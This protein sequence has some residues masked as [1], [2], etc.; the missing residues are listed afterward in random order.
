MET[1]NNPPS[2]P[3]V[4]RYGGYE[5]EGG[6][7]ATAMI[8]LYRA[9]ITR[10][11]SWRSRLDV[12]TNWAVVAMGAALSFAFGQPNTHHSVILLFN[13]LITLFL[14]IEARR[15][16]YFELWSY[17][18]RLL[19]T[20][21][22]AAMLIPPFTPR[23]AWSKDLAASLLRPEFPITMWEAV[24]RRLRRNY[25]WIYLT[26]GTAWFA[27]LLLFPTG[28]NTWAEIPAHARMGVVPGEVVL[29]VVIVFYVILIALGI[30]TQRFR[31]SVGEVL[32]RNVEDIEELKVHVEA[33]ADKNADKAKL[34]QGDEGIVNKNS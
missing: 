30:Y 18:V 33:E 21:F 23:A 32:Y 20:D 12:T 26:L 11:N 8:H 28:V 13:L 25:M 1:D 29:V 10:A 19:E 24:G 16:R 34:T 5:M 15:Y 27:R 9:E 7:F 22:F 31:M 17:R 2:I 14:L 3:K 4:W 6:A